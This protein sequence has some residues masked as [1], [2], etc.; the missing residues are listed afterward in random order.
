MKIFKKTLKNFENSQNQLFDAIIYGI[1]HYRY[2]GEVQITKEKILEVLG[3][4]SFYDL[5]EIE[6]EILLDRTFFGYFDRCF[7]LNNF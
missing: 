6:D 1:M 2:I 5:K 7:K 4:E 3:E